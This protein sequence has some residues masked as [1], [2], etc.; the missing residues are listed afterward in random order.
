MIFSLIEAA[1]FKKEI[2]EKFCVQ[3]HFH[4]GC[5]GQYFT[6]E[7]PTA[8]LKAYITDFFARRN[9]NVHFSE[10]RQHFSV[11]EGLQC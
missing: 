10:N 1:S 6:L 7:N 2:Y 3:I 4:D 11:E 8:E 5:G 9:L